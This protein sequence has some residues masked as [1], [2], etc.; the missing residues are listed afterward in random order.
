MR[1]LVFIFKPE[2]KKIGKKKK[3]KKALIR[4]TYFTPNFLSSSWMVDIFLLINE[5][6]VREVVLLTSLLPKSAL[7]PWNRKNINIDSPVNPSKF[8]L[9]Y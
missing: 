7:S 4:S 5:E 2:I 8:F 9:K 3:K 6:T 1:I